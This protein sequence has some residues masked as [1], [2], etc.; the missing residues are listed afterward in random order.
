[1]RRA[2]GWLGLAAG[3]GGCGGEVMIEQVQR[4]AVSAGVCSVPTDPAQPHVDEGVFDVALRDAYAA[5][6][7]LQS[8][9]SSTARLAG[10][11]VEIHEGSP[12]GPLVGVPF[13]VY[14]SATVPADDGVPGRRAATFELVPRQIAMALR[15]AVCVIDPSRPA[16]PACPVPRYTSADRRLVIAL[17]AF[18]ETSGGSDFE[19]RP[20]VFP[21]RVCCGC[22]VTFPTEAR[23]P[24]AVH[25]S[26]NCNQGMAP[27]TPA[28]CALGQ[29][30]PVDCRLCSVTNP[31][32]QPPGHATDPAAAAC[33][34]R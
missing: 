28:V 4:P 31:F 2:V 25:R 23:A 30:L 1:M 33:D 10:V 11:V 18:G 26:P 29:D 19:A 21:V 34:T 24:D 14:Q 27:P 5:N 17:K 22:L 9:L 13:T 15:A 6:L 16:T 12:E 7:L 32:C 3:L 20:F 8:T